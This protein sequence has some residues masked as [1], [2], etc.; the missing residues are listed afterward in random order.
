MPVEG[1]DQLTEVLRAW[2]PENGR[3]AEVVEHAAK[4]SVAPDRHLGIVSDRRARVLESSRQ[5]VDRW[6]VS[7]AVRC[8]DERLEHGEEEKP[9]E[10]VYDALAALTALATLTAVVPV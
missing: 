8:G 3:F 5:I 10:L 2:S 4:F 7:A 9:E 1:R 6:H